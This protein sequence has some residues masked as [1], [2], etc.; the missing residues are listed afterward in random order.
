MGPDLQNRLARLTGMMREVSLLTDPRE[1]IEAYGR[2]LEGLEFISLSRRGLER[3]RWRVTRDGRKQTGRARRAAAPPVL[4][5]GLL[6][7]IVYSSQAHVLTDFKVPADDASRPLIT[8]YKTLVAVP[9]FDTGEALNWVVHL[10]RDEEFGANEIPDLVWQS[11]LFGRMTYNLVLSGRLREANAALDAELA[12]V[13]RVQRA[14]LPLSCPECG[15]V[16]MAAESRPARRAGGDYYGARRLAD[17]RV[18]VVVADVSGHTAQATVLMGMVHALVHQSPGAGRV[19]GVRQPRDVPGGAARPRDI[20]HGPVRRRRSLGGPDLR[21]RGPPAR[22]PGTGRRRHRDD[23]RR[24][25]AAPGDRA[26]RAVRRGLRGPGTRGL[27]GVLH[28][29][30]ERGAQRAGRAVRGR[31]ARRVGAGVAPERSRPG[32]HGA[33]DHG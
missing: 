12:D 32:G 2:S 10:R 3:P 19:A 17:G 28:G 13:A 30:R 8:G 31:S 26:G 25:R 22:T 16:R 18:G 15:R 7:E 6:G 5:G 1:M 27:T 21:E 11:S 24:G 20:R 9:H 4:E 33:A 29:R 14:L 23:G